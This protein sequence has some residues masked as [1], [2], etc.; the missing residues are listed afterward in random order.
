[1]A[2]LTLHIGAGIELV[3][4]GNEESMLD[5]G[6]W[7]Q[8]LKPG[9][10]VFMSRPYGQ[11][12]RVSKVSRTTETQIIVGSGRFHKKDGSQVGGGTW[13]TSYLIQPTEELRQQIELSLLQQQA[14]KMVEDLKVPN[15][16][17]GCRTFIV[18][19]KPYVSEKP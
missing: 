4:G 5:S 11:A 1:M 18:A 2:R 16:I 3:D 12:P 9:D 8:N 13:S 17:E 7:L 14:G 6:E 10:E 19:L 15:D